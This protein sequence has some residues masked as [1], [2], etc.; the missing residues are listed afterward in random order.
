MQNPHKAKKARPG[1]G[2]SN[3]RSLWSEYER[4][5]AALAEKNLNPEQY[6]KAIRMLAAQ[7]RL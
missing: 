6:G 5:K 7:L 3:E 2:R 1:H 4:R